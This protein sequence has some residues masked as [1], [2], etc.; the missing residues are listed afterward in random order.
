MRLLTNHIPVRLLLLFSCNALFSSLLF[1]LLS[2]FSFSSDNPPILVVV[3]LV[4]GNLIV[5]VYRLTRASYYFFQL[6][7]PQFQFLLL[8]VS[9]SFSPLSLHRIFSL[10]SCS[11]LPVVGVVAV[12]TELPSP[13][14]TN[15][16][17]LHVNSVPFNFLAIYPS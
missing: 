17:A 7:K 4:S 9:F 11:R 16:L 2:F 1:I 5:S 6:S 3:G 14:H 10:S 15:L 8:D 13:S 12:R